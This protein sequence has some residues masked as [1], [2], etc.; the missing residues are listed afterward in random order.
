MTTKVPATC[1]SHIEAETLY[2]NCSTPRHLDPPLHQDLHRYIE[3]IHRYSY[4]DF[5][6]FKLNQPNFHTRNWVGWMDR[7]AD[8]LASA[9]FA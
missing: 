4:Y 9:G 5:S 6:L 7:V 1:A 3:V 2:G 8:R